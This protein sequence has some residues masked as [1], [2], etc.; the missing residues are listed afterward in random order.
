ME[1]RQQKKKGKKNQRKK[2]K[3][4]PSFITTESLEPQWRAMFLLFKGGKNKVS[5]FQLFRFYFN[6]DNRSKKESYNR[7]LLKPGK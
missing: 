4:G 2:R 3:I 5:T 1:F 6:E 7:C